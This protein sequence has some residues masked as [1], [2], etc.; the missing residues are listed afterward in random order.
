MDL[1][2]YGSERL[3][4][5]TVRQYNIPKIR[6]FFFKFALKLYIGTHTV[7]FII[8]QVILKV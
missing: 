6:C 4:N 5:N 3:I 8:L 2:R 7:S 1:I